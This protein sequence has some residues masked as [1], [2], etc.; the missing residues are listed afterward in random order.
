VVLADPDHRLDLVHCGLLLDDGSWVQGYV[1]S[2]SSD[3]R[4]TGDRE[5]VLGP[6][7]E[8]VPSASREL[9]AVE[10]SAVVVPAR[11]IV[12]FQVSYVS[13]NAPGSRDA[14]SAGST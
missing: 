11:R 1:D 5:L 13:P 3:V 6:P 12:Y 9:E 2:F 8:R 4:E 14:T 7:I 10:V